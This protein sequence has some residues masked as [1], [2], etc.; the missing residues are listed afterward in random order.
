MSELSDIDLSYNLNPVC[1]HCGY[2]M[3]DAWQ[4]GDN[5]QEVECNACEKD[6]F[7]SIDVDVTYST[8]KK[9]D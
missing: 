5:D 1:P 2:E 6:Y 3:Q 9:A 4:L 7:V 8:S